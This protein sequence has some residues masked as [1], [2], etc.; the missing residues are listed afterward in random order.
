MKVYVITAGMY[1]DYGIVG[2]TL[3][4]ETA[5]KYIEAYN[6]NYDEDDDYKARIEVYD[7]ERIGK[8]VNGYHLYKCMGVWGEVQTVEELNAER[9]SIFTEGDFSEYFRGEYDFYT[10]EIAKTKEQAE[11]VAA[12]RMTKYMNV[13]GIIAR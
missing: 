10:I 12:E 3:D 4:H 13:K 2:V 9:A 5:R 11:K 6:V 1:S 8:L 7:T